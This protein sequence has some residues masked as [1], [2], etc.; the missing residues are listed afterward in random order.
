MSLPDFQ[1]LLRARF[2]RVSLITAHTSKGHTFHTSFILQS[3]N[4]PLETALKDSNLASP[5]RR[6]QSTARGAGS[7]GPTRSNR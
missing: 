7:S 1:K 5:R 3:S 2:S 4:F 6:E